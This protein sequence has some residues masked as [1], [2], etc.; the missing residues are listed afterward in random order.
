MV[1]S[2]ITRT[3][4]LKTWLPL[5]HLVLR[6]RR[7]CRPVLRGSRRWWEDGSDETLFAR[8][9][10]WCGVIVRT[11]ANGRSECVSVHQRSVGSVACNAGRDLGDSRRC[12][13]SSDAWG[14]GCKVR[15]DCAD[16][17]HR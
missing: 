1:D 8:C 16:G 13:I 5:A 17:H 15:L 6:F 7:M 4:L 10:Y 12:G 14:C 9:G 2:R 11:P 3:H